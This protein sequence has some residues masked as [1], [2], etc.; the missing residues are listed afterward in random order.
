MYTY[1]TMRHNRLK[2]VDVP[3][4][5]QLYARLGYTMT[6]GEKTSGEEFLDPELNKV[7]MAQNVAKEVA[8]AEAVSAKEEK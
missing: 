5:S 6:N 3:K 2:K 4:P 1:P 8:K 7:Q